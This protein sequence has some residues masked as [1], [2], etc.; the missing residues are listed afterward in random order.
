MRVPSSPRCSATQRPRGSSNSMRYQPLVGPPRGPRASAERGI[1]AAEETRCATG[2]VR[3][4]HSSHRGCQLSTESAGTHGRRNE[5][6][7][8]TTI[9]DVAAH[10]GVSATTV[11]H[12]LNGTRRVEP[13]TVE[14]V[15]RSVEV[16]GYRPN[17]VARS[18]RHGPTLHRGH[19]DARCVQPVLRRPCACPGGRDL[20]TGLQRFSATRTATSARKASTSMCCCPSRWTASC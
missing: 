11:S 8:V 5:P 14:R 17:A 9:R 16:L 2:C 3:T 19:R 4:V 6:P 12:V 18:M 13:R 1:R 15:R 20:R 10:A 7:D